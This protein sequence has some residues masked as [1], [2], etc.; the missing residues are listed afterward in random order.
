MVKRR[1]PR[2]TFHRRRA[3][4]PISIAPAIK[5]RLPPSQPE[6]VLRDTVAGPE[7]ACGAVVDT[8]KVAVALPLLIAAV[9][10]TEQLISTVVFETAQLKLTVPVNP[11]NAVMVMLVEPLCPGAAIVMLDGA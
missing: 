1:I 6:G 10:G 7:T 2:P 5:A 8:V 4:T 3:G 11:F 9:A